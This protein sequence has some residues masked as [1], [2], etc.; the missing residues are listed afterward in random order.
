LKPF[1]R[2]YLWVA[3]LI[4]LLLAVASS[5]TEMMASSSILYVVLSKILHDDDLIRGRIS[6]SDCMH[7]PDRD[8]C[9]GG[10]ITRPAGGESSVL[11]HFQCRPVPMLA[12]GYI[13]FLRF[14]SFSDGFWGFGSCFQMIDDVF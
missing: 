9:S 13:L 11:Q 14:P 12:L 10:L 3:A 1:K 7:W 4:G 6:R 8:R 2:C 5:V